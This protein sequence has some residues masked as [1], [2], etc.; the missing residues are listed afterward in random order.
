[1]QDLQEKIESKYNNEQSN[2]KRCFCIICL[3]LFI[4]ILLLGAMGYWNY[5]LY[6]DSQFNWDAINNLIESKDSLLYKI[7]T[8]QSENGRISKRV[9]DLDNGN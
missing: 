7:N 6:S 2:A 3:I 9:V 8:L 4:F 5:I 1:M